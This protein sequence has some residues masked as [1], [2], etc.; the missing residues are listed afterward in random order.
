MTDEQK[1]KQTI[2][3]KTH[4]AIQ[5]AMRVWLHEKLTDVEFLVLMGI[6][7]AV[8]E[9]VGVEGLIDPN[10]GKRLEKEKQNAV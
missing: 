9:E 5:G 3:T 8:L 4:S 1:R 6:L 7:K 2:L 10:T